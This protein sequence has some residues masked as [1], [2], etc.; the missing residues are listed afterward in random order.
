MRTRGE[1]L[2]S[3]I[4]FALIGAVKVVRGL[5]KGLSNDERYAVADAAVS[6]MKKY[7]DPWKLDEELPRP[8]GDTGHGM[9]AS[10]QKPSTSKE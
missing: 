9:P 6:Q 10:W 4:S 8:T 3:A 5:G 1:V 7:G 2:S